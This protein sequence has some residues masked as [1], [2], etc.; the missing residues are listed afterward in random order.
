MSSTFWIGNDQLDDDQRNAVQ[1]IPETE[2]FLLT[3]PAGSGKTNIL[4]LRAKWLTLKRRSNYK[5]IVFTSSLR[6]FVEEGCSRYDLDPNSV[7]TQRKFFE[8][9]LKEYS[10]PFDRSNNF[11]EDRIMLAGKVMSLI[12]EKRIS[13]EYCW[14]L[15]VDEAQDYTDTEL[16]VFRG[17][18]KH[19][20][21]ASDSRQSIYKTT[22]TPGLLET[23]VN[24]NTVNL[25]YHYRSGLN[26]CK[27]ADAILTD[28]VAYP[29]VQTE[30]RYSEARL[31]S[32]VATVPCNSFEEQLN[33]IIEI[34]GSQ[35]SLYPDERIGVLFPKKEQVSQFEE[36]LAS[37][38]LWDNDRIWY[39]TLHGAKGWEFRAVHLG[40]C[41]ALYRMGATQ[42]RLI[43]TG[44]LR[45]KTSVHLYYSGRIPGY[46]EAALAV[47]E[48]PRSDPKMDELFRGL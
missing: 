33:T 21:L 8:D 25:R 4:L 20:V 12:E 32:S 2:S 14:S 10:I 22:H 15:L 44:I 45:G 3:G 27:V 35:L 16:R 42:K 26:L 36:K 19:L 23:L 6:K 5:F 46:L 17:L 48:P 41:E 43:Y 40:G 11:E 28:T 47:L 18:T 31:P 30:C 38:A 24:G 7:V 34:L 13:D 9:I 39:D 29:R 37:S 1:G